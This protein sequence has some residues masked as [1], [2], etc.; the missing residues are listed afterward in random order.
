MLNEK[1]RSGLILLT[2]PHIKT[3]HAFTTRF[4]GV[5]R[6]PYAGLNLSL[7][8]GDDSEAVQENF[9]RLCRAVE[10]P[11]GVS[12]VVTRQVHGNYAYTVTQA[13]AEAAQYGRVERE[14]DALVTDLKFVPLVIFAADCVPIL[15][16]DQVRGVI[17]AV[18]AG[19]RGTAADIVGSAVSA[20]RA[21]GSDPGDI[22]AAIG[23][24]ISKCCYETGADVPEAI[25]A[26]P[27]LDAGDFAEA[28]GSAENKFFVDLKGVNRSRLIYYGVAAEN[29]FVSQECTYCTD[30]NK[31]WSH[32]R[33]GNLRGCQAAIIMLV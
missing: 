16:C 4:G 5:S 25:G 20:M 31:Y 26:M 33:S 32:R 12:P 21:L 27:G 15:L 2:A 19:W 13:D 6:G 17:A 9:R 30:E 28:S 10:C 11:P 24:A 18:H 8:A 3:A 29:I 1:K 7:S 14:A 22:R 23:P